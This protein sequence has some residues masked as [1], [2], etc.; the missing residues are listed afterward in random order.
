MTIG[1]VATPN[2]PLAPLVIGTVL[3]VIVY[4]GGHVSGGHYNPAV[5]LAVYLRG[6]LPAADVVPY[7][8]AQVLGALAGAYLSYMLLDQT[9]A[10]APAATA[11]TMTA[12]MV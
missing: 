3:M 10:P 8:A 1:L 9:F 12:L 4:M 7:I 6:K 5:T 2:H 11:T